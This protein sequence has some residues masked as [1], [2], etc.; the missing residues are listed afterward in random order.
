MTEPIIYE[1]ENNKIQQ[2]GAEIAQKGRFR[3][4]NR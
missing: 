4:E 2:I 1:R 3:L